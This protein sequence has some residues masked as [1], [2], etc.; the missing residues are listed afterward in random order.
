MKM[1]NHARKVKTN[2]MLQPLEN[3]RNFF[4]RRG[5][6]VRQPQDEKKAPPRTR[7]DRFSKFEKRC[8]GCGDTKDLVGDCPHQAKAKNQR[9]YVSGAWSDSDDN[10]NNETCLTARSS[11]EVHTETDFF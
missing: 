3:S 4:K 5:R 9:A 10:D 8:F 7:E 2:N 1:R 11:K 6:F